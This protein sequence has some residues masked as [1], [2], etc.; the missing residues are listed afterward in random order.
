MGP[1]KRGKTI[2]LQREIK[3]SVVLPSIQFF[4]VKVDTVPVRDSEHVYVV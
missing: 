2:R 4:V 1:E 3:Q